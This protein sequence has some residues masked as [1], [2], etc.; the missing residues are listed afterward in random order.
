VAA[1]R[2]VLISGQTRQT[3]DP[4]EPVGLAWARAKKFEKKIVLDPSRPDPTRPTRDNPCPTRPEK[5]GNK[6]QKTSGI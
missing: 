3:H 4:L 5:P 1:I 2:P 6:T